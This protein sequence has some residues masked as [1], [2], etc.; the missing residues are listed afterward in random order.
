MSLHPRLSPKTADSWGKRLGLCRRDSDARRIYIS[1]STRVVSDGR[2]F[3]HRCGRNPGY[4]RSA[5]YRASAGIEPRIHQQRAN[6]PG[7]NLR[8]E[9][10]ENVRV[11]KHWE[12][13]DAILM[14]ISANACS[15]S[16]ERVKM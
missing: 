10:A 14:T 12:E 15:H 16:M 1:H 8:S 7:D 2:R 5:R 11:R 4:R 13:S 6:E 9:D 3:L